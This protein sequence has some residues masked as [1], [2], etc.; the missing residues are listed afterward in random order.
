MEQEIITIVITGGP[1]A[2]KSTAMSRIQS[3]F[4]TLGYT[5][6]FVAETATELITG[7]IAPWS[8]GSNTDYQKCQME[9]QMAKENVYKEAA[10]TMDSKKVLIVCDRGVSDSCPGHC[11]CQHGPKFHALR[12]GYRIHGSRHK[13]NA[14][15]ILN[16]GKVGIFIHP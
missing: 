1:C 7:G 12:K 4:S 11:E 10:R 2:G 3:Y 15:I 14:W 8:C 5:V 9:L 16:R 6:L 13:T